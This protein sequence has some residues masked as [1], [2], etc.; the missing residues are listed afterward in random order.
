[1]AL[2]VPGVMDVKAKLSQQDPFLSPR[3]LIDLLSYLSVWLAANFC[4]LR[5]GMLKMASLELTAI[6]EY[7]FYCLSFSIF[8]LAATLLEG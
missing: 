5:T 2:V 4:V 6:F 3:E 1:M 7:C 8:G